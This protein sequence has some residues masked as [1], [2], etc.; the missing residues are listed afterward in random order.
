MKLFLTTFGGN[1]VGR[2]SSRAGSSAASP[3]RIFQSAFT[4]VEIAISL[5]VIG[6]ALVAIIGVLPLGMNVQ[7]DN[8]EETVVNQDATVFLD[9]ISHGARGLDDLTNYV[10]AITNYWTFFPIN[11][12]TPQSGIDG[13][14]LQGSQITKISSPPFFPITNGLNIVGLLSTPE[15][16]DLNFNP[17]N[18]LFSGGYSNH[19]ITYVRSLSGAATEKPPQDNQIIQQDA[20]GY[21]LLCV[22]AAVAVDTNIFNPLLYTNG[23]PA[24]ARQLAANL[25][26]VR[27]TFLW[28]VLPNG[29]VGSGRQTYR[30][31]VAGQILPTNSIGQMLYFFQSQS[32][33]NAP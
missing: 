26:E 14:S 28:P 17:T 29:G 8:R 15:F 18:N 33:T 27:L 4:L 3:H 25:R 21:R 11:N 20:F 24:Y 1:P 2:A 13:Y 12:G 9:A 5:A 30:A 7:R 16:T 32:F 31:T 10:Y 22:N 23:P 19:I 6:I